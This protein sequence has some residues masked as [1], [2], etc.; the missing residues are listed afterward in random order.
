MSDSL[1]LAGFQSV[2]T[3]RLTSDQELSIRPTAFYFVEADKFKSA[4]KLA[5]QR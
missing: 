5:F 1:V 4:T 3:L 2:I